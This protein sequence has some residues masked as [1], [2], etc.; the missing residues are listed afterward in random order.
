MILE[1]PFSVLGFD[2]RELDSS[3][4]VG[5]PS[6]AFP[7]SEWPGWTWVRAGVP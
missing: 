3:V 4:A 5:W 6:G 2:S 7:V 1:A